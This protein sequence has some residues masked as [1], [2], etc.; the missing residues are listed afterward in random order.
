MGRGR[1]GEEQSP[2]KERRQRRYM[3]ARLVTPAFQAFA[4]WIAPPREAK[5]VPNPEQPAIQR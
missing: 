1:G 5:P 3:R 4:E 2:G